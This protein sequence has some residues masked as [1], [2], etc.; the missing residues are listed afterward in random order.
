MSLELGRVGVP[1]G[2]RRV[3]GAV[4]GVTVEG[5]GGRRGQGDWPNAVWVKNMVTRDVS[6][7][8]GGSQEDLK[9]HRQSEAVAGTGG[10]V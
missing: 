5:G 2:P 9:P 3:L 10:L 7:L 1:I 4:R 6:G 8:W